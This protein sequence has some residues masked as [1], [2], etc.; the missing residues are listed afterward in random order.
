MNLNE[1]TLARMT[2]GARWTAKNFFSTSQG[3]RPALAFAEHNTIVHI[4]NARGVNIQSAGRQGAVEREILLPAG[5]RFEIESHS[6]SPKS[7]QHT[8]YMRQLN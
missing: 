1:Q 2:P 4:R 7:G 5:R 3:T 6:V 8:I